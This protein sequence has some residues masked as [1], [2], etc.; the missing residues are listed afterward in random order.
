MEANTAPMFPLDRIVQ[1][2]QAIKDARTVRR[3]AYE[4]EDLILEE[5]QKKLDMLLLDMLNQQG[6][7]SIAT[8]DGTVIRSLKLKPSAA[9]WSAI[10]AWIMQDA[11]R[12][13]LLERRLKTAFIKEYMEENNNAIPPG[14]NVHREYEVSVR[15]PTNS[16]PASA[17]SDSEEA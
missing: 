12:G 14:I 5:D 7:S 6:A 4:K 3:H 9:D 15:R 10:W 16:K 17:A 2:R 13:E 11:T 8:E 1:A